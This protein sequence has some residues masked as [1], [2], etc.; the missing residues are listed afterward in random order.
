MLNEYEQRD[1]DFLM[2]VTINTGVLG[3]LAFVLQSLAPRAGTLITCGILMFVLGGIGSFFAR[4]L[5][6]SVRSFTYWQSLMTAL[7]AKFD[8]DGE[9]FDFYDDLTRTEFFRGRVHKPRRVGVG[10]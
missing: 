1:R 4:A 6:G 3:A 8:L 9:E 5:A 2:Y 10:V 7:L